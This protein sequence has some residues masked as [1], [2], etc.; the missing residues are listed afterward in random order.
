MKKRADRKALRRAA[1]CA[2]EQRGFKV[3]QLTG[4]GIV[5]GTRLEAVK[6]E[7]A[8]EIAVRT[9]HDRKVGL[10]RHPSGKWRT[11][12]RVGE[13]VVAV[14]AL[15]DPKS[16]EV[17]G[18]TPAKLIRAFDAL[19][20]KVDKGK[21]RKTAYKSPIFIALDPLAEDGDGLR[22]GL[23]GKAEWSR[24]MPLNSEAPDLQLA[25][26]KIGFIERVR[27]EFAELNGVDVNRVFVNFHIVG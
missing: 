19:A 16:A 24:I 4:M 7:V 12:P 17:L 9:S 22:S 18:F 6:A 10:M 25:E 26:G 3:R 5:P 21:S 27:R 13:V 20:A 8:K 11:V 23:K 1:R 2:L 14:Q 15:D